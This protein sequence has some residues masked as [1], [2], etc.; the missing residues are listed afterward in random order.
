ME[1]D[2]HIEKLFQKYLDRQHSKEELAELLRH[3]DSDS[4]KAFLIDL[5]N[6]KIKEKD[7]Q[8]LDDQL[9]QQ[10]SER[11]QNKIFAETRPKKISR[12]LPLWISSAAALLVLGLS[13]TYFIYKFSNEPVAVKQTAGLDSDI[14][15]GGNK[16]RLRLANGEEIELS[17]QQEGIKTSNGEISYLDGTSISSSNTVQFVTLTTPVAGQFQVQLPDGTKAW[18][19]A[20]SSIIYPTS[21]TNN[22]RKISIT[23][24]VYL[25]VA[26]D[27]KRKFIISAQNQEIEVLG[28]S[29]NVNTYGDNGKLFTTLAEGSL[30]ITSTGNGATAILKPGYQ[31]VIDK[32]ASITVNK[33]DASGIT[34]WK[35]GFYHID[36]QTLSLFGKQ[37]ER[38]YDVSIDMGIKGDTHLSA[39][40]PRDIKLSELLQAIET[41]TGIK[42]KTEGRRI[43]A[44]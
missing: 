33:V 20:T 7:Q 22:Q 30:K 25:E 2:D 44:Q 15:P 23:G 6:E 9:I 32:N 11:I 34:A 27:P 21:F 28:T 41:K 31:A 38:W 37:I 42:F 36:N 14:A 24:E 17:G 12:R 29:F 43:S 10:I 3:F 26:K 5:I 16:A 1:R 13:A 8:E 39:V 18:L 4:N 19:N 35:D 40:I